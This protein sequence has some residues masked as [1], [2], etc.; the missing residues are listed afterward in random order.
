MYECFSS[1]FADICCFSYCLSEQKKTKSIPTNIFNLFVNIVIEPIWYG[2]VYFSVCVSR[3]D[4]FDGAL[5]L[6]LQS[7]AKVTLTL[8]RKKERTNPDWILLRKWIIANDPL[9]K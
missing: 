3:L 1:E 7:E 8:V 5:K 2:S 4:T 6:R 9:F